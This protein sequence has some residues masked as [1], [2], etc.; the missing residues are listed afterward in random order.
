[1]LSKERYFMKKFED[2]AASE[3]KKEKR[4]SFIFGIVFGLS[5]SA[6]YFCFGGLIAIGSYL[7]KQGK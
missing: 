4:T 1:M 5:T 7:V 6:Q 3:Y 2:G